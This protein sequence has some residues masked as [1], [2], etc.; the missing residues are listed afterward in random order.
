MPV[1]GRCVVTTSTS[2]AAGPPPHTWRS[3]GG[4]GGGCPGN[5][6][7]LNPGQPSSISITIPVTSTTDG[8]CGPRPNDHSARCLLTQWLGSTLTG[9]YPGDRLDHVRVVRLCDLA[10]GTCLDQ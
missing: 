5:N 4:T 9:D 1:G 2:F 3:L 10:E 8:P 6:E 7:T